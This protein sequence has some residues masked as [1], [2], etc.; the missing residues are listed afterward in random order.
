[1]QL[2]SELS[3]GGITFQRE[4]K[5]RKQLNE[6]ENKIIMTQNQIVAARPK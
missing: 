3:A 4:E 5:M 2:S 1:M 6:I